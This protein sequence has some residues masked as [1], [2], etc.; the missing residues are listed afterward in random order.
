MSITILA[1]DEI[2]L[3]LCVLILTLTVVYF[4]LHRPQGFPPGPFGWPII[5]SLPSIIV[6]EPYKAMAKLSKTYGN[7]IGLKTGRRLVVILNGYD[8]IRTALV[9]N[10][11]AFSGREI[12]TV[13]HEVF[14]GRGLINID[15]NDVWKEERRFTLMALRKCGMGSLRLEGKILR[16]IK[17]MMA[18]LDE[19]INQPI[20]L[21]DILTQTPANVITTILLGKRFDNNDTTFL[22][23]LSL[24]HSFTR[25]VNRVGASNFFP[26]LRFL[27]GM[28]YANEMH[29]IIDGGAKIFRQYI[30]DYIRNFDSNSEPQCFIDM[31]ISRIETLGDHATMLYDSLSYTLWDLYSAGTETISM[32]LNWAMQYMVLNPKI[33]Y[34]LQADIDDVVGASRPVSTTDRPSLPYVDATLNEVHRMSTIVPFSVSHR[35]TKNAWINGYFIPSGTYVLPNLWSAHHDATV[36]D[37]PETFRPDRFMKNGSLSKRLELI[38]FGLGHR[39]CIGKQ[40]ANMELFLIFTSLIQN[41]RFSIPDNIKPPTSKCLLRAVSVLDPYIVRVQKRL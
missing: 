21:L 36:W 12:D 13:Q 39:E 1:F 16:E 29:A 28:N 38:P 37:D 40:L 22:K 32:T 33:Q 6:E 26:T 17:Y 15:Y 27:P 14:N 41:Y 30:K 18:D 20:D 7:I 2:N 23:L 3:L 25:T 34:K 11:L 19:R 35:V 4:W 9:K 8:T 5:G 10:A 31:A 24:Q